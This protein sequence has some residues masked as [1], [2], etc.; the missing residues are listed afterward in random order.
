[1]RLQARKW[2]HLCKFE[3]W[4]AAPDAQESDESCRRMK[5]RKADWKIEVW[6]MARTGDREAR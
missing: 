5:V 4:T 1:M 6:M 3:D 2:G